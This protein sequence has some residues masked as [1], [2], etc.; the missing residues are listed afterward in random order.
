[1]QLARGRSDFMCCYVVTLEV[2]IEIHKQVAKL[3]S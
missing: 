3:Y 2:T 1:M